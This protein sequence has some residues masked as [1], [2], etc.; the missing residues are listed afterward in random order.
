MGE[1]SCFMNREL[2]WLLFNERV[3]NEA[4]NPA[5]PLAERLSFASIYQTNLDEFYMVRVGSLMDQIEDGDD[6][7]DDKTGMTAAE[8][9]TEILKRTRKLEGKRAAIYEQLMGEIQ[10]H[11]INLINYQ[12]L[13][14]KEGA[15]L[16]A[17]FDVHIAPFLSPM[18][19]GKRQPI[20]FLEN[21]R[22]YIIVLL[23]TA[24]GAKRIGI[25]PCSGGAFRR[26]IEIPTRPGTYILSEELI[27]HF[28]PKL[29]AGY[30]IREKSIMRVTRNADID[31]NEVYDEELDYRNMMEKLIRQR[32][33]LNP[34]RVEFSRK[35]NAQAKVELSKFL[36]VGVE[37]MIDVRTPLDLSFVSQIQNV[38]RSRERPELFY[39]R[40]APQSSP[41]LRSGERVMDQVLKKDVLLSYPFE[42]MRP[43]ITLLHEAA[44]DDNV[45][46][47]KMTLYRVANH[48]Q[49]VDELVEAA[50]NGKE[51]VVLI[52][53]RARFD[54]ANNIEMSRRLED[55]G[56]QILYGLEKFKVHS[57]LCLIT[58]ATEAGISY[59]TQI[60]TGNYNEK[61]ARAYTDLS[62]MTA[63]QTIGQDAAEVFHELQMGATVE[64]TQL[65]LVAP[66]CLQQPVLDKIDAQIARAQNGED[67][68]IGLKMNSLTDKVIMEKLIAASQA[69][70]RIDMIVRGICCLV[71]G[72]PGETEHIR[73]ISV[74]GRF[75]EHSRI[76]RFGKG[77]GEEVYIA[78]ADFMTRNTLKRVEVAVPLL[79]ADVRKRVCDLF[80]LVFS[81]DEKGKEFTANGVYV[82][83]ELHLPKIN[84]QE[85]LYEQAYASVPAAEREKREKTRL[86]QK[87]TGWTR[88]WTEKKTKEE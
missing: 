86:L 77:E 55:A 46:S 84:S 67:A 17:Y 20:P 47:I 31:E 76:Y 29:Y 82:D 61:T 43:F 13:S 19:I 12:K 57:K 64:H 24:K 72:I 14:K 65:L 25:V 71:P 18:I 68:Y 69:G 60:G 56:C 23:S 51:V 28:V 7:V 79:D 40:R 37:H 73:V 85:A 66:L 26:L 83:R 6:G 50:E 30:A 3:L 62:L 39:T 74:V 1:P 48:S 78:S 11:G 42:S 9:V 44:T 70:V 75:L 59:V 21:K 38:L 16:E 15:A 5:V 52:E 35:I 10:V 4:G 87:F 32:K 45:V 33:R 58:R 41:S 63:N 22:L 36:K 8:Q 88:R 53:L 27:L 54:E 2:S 49:I 34:V 81:D 80:D